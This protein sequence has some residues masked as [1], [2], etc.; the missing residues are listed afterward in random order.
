MRYIKDNL[1]KNWPK[2]YIFS[3]IKNTQLFIYL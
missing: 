3:F 2:S 1:L